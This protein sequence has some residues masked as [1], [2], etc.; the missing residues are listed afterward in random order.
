ML[1]AYYSIFGPACP[2]PVSSGVASMTQFRDE[3]TANVLAA[4]GEPGV[5]FLSSPTGRGKTYTMALAAE[6]ERWMERAF[7]YVEAALATELATP[8]RVCM[9]EEYFRTALVRGLSHSEPAEAHRIDTE[10]AAN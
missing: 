10:Y 2:D 4:I 8:S 3:Q 6:Y 5:Y 7:L 1:D 9:S